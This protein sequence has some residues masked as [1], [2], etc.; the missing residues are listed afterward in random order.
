MQEIRGVVV[1]G[2]AAPEGEILIDDRS[3]VMVVAADSGLTTAA[4][5]GIVPDAIVG[6][7]DSLADRSLLKRYPDATI[8]RHKRAK[9]WTDT[10]IGLKFLWKRAVEEVTIVGGGGGRMDHLFALLAL[11]ERARF[12]KRWLTDRDEITVVEDSVV[13]DAPENGIVSFF[14]VGPETCRMT[15]TGLRWELN[16]H[17]WTHGDVG[18]SNE[19]QDSTCRVNMLSGRLLMVRALPSRIV[20]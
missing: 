13:F 6:D 9:D 14:P 2:G 11:F 7:M 4:R 12:P 17:E 15:S 20:L 1:T 19:C 10:E 18:I 5:A 8:E 3:R 16:G